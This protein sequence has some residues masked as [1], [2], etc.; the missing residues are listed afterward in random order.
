MVWRKT[1]LLV[2][3]YEAG[4][5]THG[6]P[7]ADHLV[8]I[9]RLEKRSFPQLE[10]NKQWHSFQLILLYVQICF[11]CLFS[12]FPTFNQFLMELLYYSME[13]AYAGRCCSLSPLIARRRRAGVQL[14]VSANVK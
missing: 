6:A 1:T 9:C 4:A 2:F 8:S 5:V 3:P 14:T 12:L 13:T 11:H 7:H 10:K